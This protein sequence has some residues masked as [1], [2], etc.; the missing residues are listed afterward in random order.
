MSSAS[1]IVNTAVERPIPNARVRIAV[2]ANPG[3]RRRLRSP[4]RTLRVRRSM[5]SLDVI[6][7]E[8][9]NRRHPDRRHGHSERSEESQA[10]R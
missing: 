2:S 7:N 10:S 4:T 6:P 1:A 5:S 8:V 3:V 9:R